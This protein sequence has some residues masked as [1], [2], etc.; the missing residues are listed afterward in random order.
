[1]KHGGGLILSPFASQQRLLTYKN[2]SGEV[3]PPYAAVKLK[4]SR[5]GEA[6]AHQ[7]Y[8]PDKDDDPFVVFN[9]PF[10]VQPE[11]SGFSTADYPLWA[12]LADGDGTPDNGESLGTRAGNWELHRGYEGFLVWGGADNGRVFVQI[13]VTCRETGGAGGY[14]YDVFENPCCGLPLPRTL[15][16]NHIDSTSHDGGITLDFWNAL[17]ADRPTVSSA[18]GVDDDGIMPPP[19]IPDI[20]YRPNPPAA[21]GGGITSDTTPFFWER[22]LGI[23]ADTSKVSLT[24]DT[25]G[26]RN[27]FPT[28]WSEF[29]HDFDCPE[30]D[31]GYQLVTSGGGM[32]TMR[33][34]VQEAKYYSFYVFLNLD[35]PKVFHS[36]GLGGETYSSRCAI[37]HIQVRRVKWTEEN[38]SGFGDPV[39]TT[40]HNPSWPDF[41]DYDICGVMIGSVQSGNFGTPLACPNTLICNPFALQTFMSMRQVSF[42]PYNYYT[43]NGVGAYGSSDGGY[44]YLLAECYTLRV[45]S[46]TFPPDP[47]VERMML[48]TEF[49]ETPFYYPGQPDGDTRIEVEG[50]CSENQDCHLEWQITGY[51]ITGYVDDDPDQPIYDYDHPIYGWVVVCVGAGTYT[52]SGPHINL[53]ICANGDPFPSDEDEPVGQ[54]DSFQEDSFQ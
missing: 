14:Y 1:M 38:F 4:K 15:C 34:I 7:G 18:S 33:R 28:W 26:K 46:A 31:T 40:T 30:Q 45:P 25:P 13:D 9:G 52:Q 35:Y 27:W 32:I 16:A 19:W 29:Y 20:R 48:P 24:P 37:V 23:A 51:P 36:S 3:V 42:F 49:I 6:T 5:A 22:V 54:E 11:E 12:A 10:A 50:A 41:E 44:F 43:T 53:F 39:Y 21:P 8:K 17:P 2:K 47:V